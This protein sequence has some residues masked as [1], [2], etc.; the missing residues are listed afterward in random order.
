MLIMLFGI[1]N[2]GK[3]VTGEKLAEKLNYTFLDL[4]EEIKKE[5]SNNHRK[6]Y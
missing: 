5:I 3:T 1:V 4:D 6:I 2:V